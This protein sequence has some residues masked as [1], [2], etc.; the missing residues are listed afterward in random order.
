MQDS[1]Q[2]TEP[3]SPAKLRLIQQFMQL[4][5]LQRRLDTGSFLERYALPGGPMWQPSATGSQDLATF[6]QLLETRIAALNRAY[7]R[8]RATYQREYEHHINWEFTEAELEEIVAFLSR[9][10]GQHYLGGSWR[11]EAYVGTN[12]EELEE[13]IVREAMASI[14]N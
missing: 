7:A 13:Q 6:R 14:P 4:T 2:I 12:V 10:A 3:P 8:H 11:M 5:G 9:P 1:A